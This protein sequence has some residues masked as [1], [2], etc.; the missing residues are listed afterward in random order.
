MIGFPADILQTS[1]G[2]FSSDLEL[3]PANHADLGDDV[4][5]VRL[6]VELPVDLAV[7]LAASVVVGLAFQVP[8][9]LL[10]RLSFRTQRRSSRF[11]KLSQGPK[12]ETVFSE[13]VSRSV[14]SSYLKGK[15]STRLER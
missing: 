6:D 11:V 13:A 3:E 9:S 8:A 14:V 12:S 15:Y 5:V 4:Q 7:A 2:R 10:P 1:Q